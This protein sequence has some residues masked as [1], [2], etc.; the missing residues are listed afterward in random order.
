MVADPNVPGDPVPPGAPAPAAPGVRPEPPAGPAVASKAAW[1]RWARAVRSTGVEG[2]G[3]EGTAVEEAGGPLPWAGRPSTAAERLAGF[4]RSAAVRPG[5]LVAYVALPDEV[6]LSGLWLPSP[7]APAVPAAGR[8]VA[9]TRTPE[10]G[11]LTVHPATIELEIHPLG[12]GQPRSDAPEVADA[13]IAVVAVPG[14]A[15]DR[16]GRRLG[17]GGGHYDRFLARL[18]PGVLRVGIT[19]GLIVDRLP[20]EPHDI[21]MTHLLDHDGVRAV[22]ADPDRS[23]GR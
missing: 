16:A 11:H 10:A 2:I 21:T 1:R 17:R 14:L 13:D 8:P 3:V 22:D 23:S 7:G 5:W 6:D 18:D 20:S 15:F 19:G 4:L 12:F 9:L